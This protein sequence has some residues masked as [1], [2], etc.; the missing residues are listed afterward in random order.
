MMSKEAAIH[1][2]GGGRGTEAGVGEEQVHA[3]CEELHAQHKRP[4]ESIASHAHTCKGCWSQSQYKTW[5]M[6]IRVIMDLASGI[7]AAKRMAGAL[8]KP[9]PGWWQSEGSLSKH[10]VG[11]NFII[12]FVPASYI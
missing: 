5:S 6:R 3:F 1:Q 4:D 7:C 11:A 10:C 12:I 2:E 9:A 8:K